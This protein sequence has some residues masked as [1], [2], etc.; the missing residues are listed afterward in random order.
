MFRDTLSSRA[1]FAGLVFFVVIVAG[2]LIYTWHVEHDIQAEKARTQKFMRQ[3]ETDSGKSS[4]TQT[5]QP[6]EP[7]NAVQNEV[8]GGKQYTT[9]SSDT[10]Q[11]NTDATPSAATL[12]NPSP[13]ITPEEIGETVAEEAERNEYPEVPP[14][15][16]F[17]VVWKASK[18][19]RA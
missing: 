17:S 2:S 19:Q 18:E 12:E 10:K 7:M 16:P 4:S 6:T 5:V 15:F 11:E 13:E 3:L 1:I 8:P 14:D 9:K